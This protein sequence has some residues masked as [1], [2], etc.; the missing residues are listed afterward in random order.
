MVIFIIILCLSPKPHFSHYHQTSSFSVDLGA[1]EAEGTTDSRRRG[2]VASRARPSPG[3][4][5]QGH[6]RPSPGQPGQAPENPNGHGMSTESPPQ[7]GT[8][9]VTE[10]AFPWHV[11]AVVVLL[12]LGRCCPSDF[13]KGASVLAQGAWPPLRCPRF[14][15]TVG[16]R[17]LA[18]QD[19]CPFLLS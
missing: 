10:V 1:Q 3:F 12:F 5:P 11:S 13:G 6:L 16:L 14:F 18:W 15:R 8:K 2:L 9:T 19:R 17:G 7:L 4:L